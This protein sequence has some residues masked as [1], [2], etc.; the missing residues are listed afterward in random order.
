MNKTTL[1]SNLKKY[2]TFAFFTLYFGAV[3]AQNCTVNAG[4]DEDFCANDDIVLSGTVSTINSDLS[5]IQWT[6]VSQPTGA[7]VV[8]DNPTS[9]NSIVSGDFTTGNYTFELRMLCSDLVYARDTVMHTINAAP[10]GLSNSTTTFGCYSG[11]GI[12]LT[13]AALGAGESANW[14]ISTDSPFPGTFSSTT[15]NS[16][17]FYP[18]P[19][20]YECVAGDYFISTV[21][22]TLTNADGCSASKT[23]T[24]EYYFAENAFYAQAIPTASCGL[25]VDLYGSC[26]LNGSGTWTYSGPGTVTFG[27]ANAART[28]ACVDVV[29]TYTFTWTVTGGCRAG[30]D[31]DVVTFYNFGEGAIEPDAGP[32]QFFCAFPSAFSLQATPLEKG[33][34]GLW[35]QIKGLPATITD[36]T[37]PTT[38]V[39][40][41]Q[42]GGGPYVFAWEVYGEE[43]SKYDTLRMEETPKL[44]NFS[45]NLGFCAAGCTSNA[46]DIAESGTIVRTDSFYVFVQAGSMPDLQVQNIGGIILTLR[47]LAYDNTNQLIGV[48]TL[49]SSVLAPGDSWYVN[50]DDLFTSIYSNTHHFRIELLGRMKDSGSPIIDF[51]RGYYDFT[52]R[53]GNEC[54]ETPNSITTHDYCNVDQPTPNAGTDAV[55]PCGTTQV[56]LSG[57]DL[58]SEAGLLFYGYWVTLSGP[59]D[60]FVTGSVDRNQQQ[61]ILTGMTPGKYTFRYM[62]LDPLATNKLNECDIEYDDVAVYVSTTP[63]SPTASVLEPTVCGQGPATLVG[64]LTAGAYAG[65]WTQTAGPVATITNP[66]APTTTVTGLNPSTSYTFQWTAT[67]ACGN[68]SASV[69]FTTTATNNPSAANITNGGSC[70]PTT[71]T[72]Y[73]IRATVP[74]IGTGMWTL[75]SKPTGS[76]ASITNPNAASTSLTNMDVDGVYVLEWAV[77]NAPCGNV[78]RDTSRIFKGPNNSIN[79]VD[80]GEDLSFCG[81]AL[82]YTTSMSPTT[83]SSQIPDALIEW[84]FISGPAPVT[85]SDPFDPNTD[86]TFSTSGSY[87]LQYYVYRVDINGNICT[88]QHEDSD[89]IEVIISDQSAPPAIAGPDQELCNGTSFTLDAVDLGVGEKGSWSVLT[90]TGP[91]VS[92]ADNNDPNTTATLSDAGEVTL[93]WITFGPSSACPPNYDDVVLTYLKQ[94]YAGDD[95]TLCNATSTTLEGTEYEISGATT[96]WTGPAGITLLSPNNF[97]T[98]VSGLTPG[99]HT[100]IYAVDKGVCSLTDTVDV[101]IDAFIQAD[102]GED[103]LSCGGTTVNLNAGNSGGT[104]SLIYGTNFGTFGNPSAQNTTYGAITADSNY[105]FRYTLTNGVCESKDH[106]AAYLLKDVLLSS[107]TTDATCGNSDGAIDLTVQGNDGSPSFL[108]SNSATSED[109]SGVAA[110]VYTVTV[111]AAA[112]CTAVHST[113]LVNS[114]GPTASV[115]ISPDPVCPGENVTLTASGSG[116]SGSGYTYQWDNGNKTAVTTVNPASDTTYYVTVT[117]GSGCPNPVSV[118]V[119][120]RDVSTVDL[121]PDIQI[122]TD[123]ATLSPTISPKAHHIIYSEGFEA[124]IGTWTQ[125]T[126][127]DGNWT[128]DDLG[129]PSSGTG[130]SGGANGS[131]WYMYHETSSGATGDQVILESQSFDLSSY[132]DVELAFYYHM[133]GSQMGSLTVEVSTNG[134]SSWTQEWTLSGDQGNQWFEQVVDM[135]AYDGQSDV[136]IRF[137]STKGS[138]YRSDAAIDEISLRVPYTHLWSTGETTTSID[139]FPKSS[140]TYWLRVTDENGCEITDTILVELNCPLPVEL[141]RFE[142]SVEHCNVHLTW[143]AESEITFS[144]YELQHSTNGIS[145]RTIKTVESAPQDQALTYQYL[146]EAAGKINYYRLKMVDID[147]SIE[148]SHTLN[149]TTDCYDDKAMIIFP[150]PAIYEQQTVINVKLYSLDSQLTLTIIDLTGRNLRLMTLPAEEGWNMIRLNITDLAA[151]VYFIHHQR[152]DG[153]KEVKKFVLQE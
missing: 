18:S 152:N 151:G 112:G 40:G 143:S 20:N 3:N 6:L 133:Y 148:Y 35:T 73:T 141:S 94:P 115:S 136:K 60:P 91:G 79:N 126:G 80:A 122:C 32:N 110:G 97:S 39:T 66:N 84:S 62:L 129:T 28:S 68:G 75:L 33:Q 114:N 81:V 96:T 8:V 120:V 108:W 140:T 17:T 65:T 134:G 1:L 55:L 16:T 132:S 121:G 51:Y 13:E 50:Q 30:S 15:G 86:I 52:Y 147:G 135:S 113:M 85:I 22:Y 43:C 21:T 11:G 149:V 53:I 102:A 42:Q 128:R 111:T 12:V 131:N 125:V 38:T 74:T 47:L 95:Q 100:F 59:I 142:A 146:D 56:Q 57:N 153:T 46:M 117:D 93:R 72:S 123:T 31:S 54:E 58:S 44:P 70:F 118:F 9:A 34:T 10:S 25:C 36:D 83:L 130:P 82:P 101:Q 48:R 19:T 7:N 99:T 49:Y 103:T 77:S 106:V 5:T 78:S 116:G 144:H 37:N 45:A 145:F 61:P 139:V 109:L 76:S 105:I 150:N 88:G 14:R 127:D 27:N 69:S 41:V 104:W 92:F 2:V 107:D 23:Y 67:N 64:D 89:A 71:G 137:T 90:T 98:V 119:N 138:G 63:P 29:G 26:N 4:A 87:L 24:I 124:D